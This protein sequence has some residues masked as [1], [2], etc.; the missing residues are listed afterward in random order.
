M[1]WVVAYSR[2]ALYKRLFLRNISYSTIQ[3]ATGVSKEM[4]TTD[5][6]QKQDQRAR[7]LMRTSKLANEFLD[8]IADRPVAHRVEFE[9]LLADMNLISSDCECEMRAPSKRSSLF[10]VCESMSAVISTA[11]A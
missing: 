7:L 1:V 11:C 5:L 3:T 8:G 10:F 4:M 2:A 9:K 6:D